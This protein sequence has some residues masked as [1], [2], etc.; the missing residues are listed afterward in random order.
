V[1]KDGRPRIHPAVFRP[2]QARVL[3]VAGPP[4]PSR[5]AR[6]LF[7]SPRLPSSQ[8]NGCWQEIGRALGNP[9]LAV[10]RG[11]APRGRRVPGV[12]S[13]GGACFDISSKKG[14]CCFESAF[15]SRPWS[16]EELI[17]KQN[18]CSLPAPNPVD[19]G[20]APKADAQCQAK[21]G[22]FIASGREPGRPGDRTSSLSLIPF[23]PTPRAVSI[24]RE[25][26]GG[27][28]IFPK[29]RTRL[30]AE[31]SSGLQAEWRRRDGRGVPLRPA[32]TR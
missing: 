25:T 30:W 22:L 26:G 12:P 27:G 29:P 21:S 10:R 7:V 5:L 6:C 20:A 31:L 17:H 4:P 24:P 1:E 13:P 9:R 8:T 19:P 2:L 16:A 23:L 18:L 32:L 3:R 14:T 11:G 15:H 28:S